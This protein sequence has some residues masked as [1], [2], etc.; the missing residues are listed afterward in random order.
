M[1]AHFSPPFAIIFMHKIET[2]ALEKLKSDHNISTELYARYIDDIIMGPFERKDGVV[3]DILRVFNEINANI[4]FTMEIPTTDEP[5]NFLDISITVLH[6]HIQYEWYRKACHSGILLREDSSVPYHTKKNF[7]KSTLETIEKRCSSTDLADKN[8]TR[9]KN[10]LTNNGYNDKIITKPNQYSGFNNNNRMTKKKDASILTLD[11]INDSTTQKINNIIRKHDLDVKLVTK[12][13]PP[14]SNILAP[15][16]RINK[17]DNCE[18]CNNIESK[19]NCNVKNVVYQ[20]KCKLC[21]ENYIGQTARPLHFR[22]Q[23]HKYALNNNKTEASALSEHVE[24]T[25]KTDK[26]DM[27]TFEFSI[28]EKYNTPVECKIGEAMWIRARNPQ[29]NR[30]R[31]MTYW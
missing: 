10:T 19:Y 11:Y 3:N 27:S 22:Y 28:V 25:H 16:K 18:I 12:P 13:P 30:K 5:L 17:H 9:F 24:K 6:R 26:V 31:E 23:E 20:F 4:K 21:K 29:I 1:G 7:I 2:K 15:R 14:L 8:K